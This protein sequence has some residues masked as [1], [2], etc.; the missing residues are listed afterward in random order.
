MTSTSPRTNSSNSNNCGLRGEKFDEICADFADKLYK[1]DLA[2]APEELKAKIRDEAEE[3]TQQWDEDV[4]SSRD[5]KQW[6][7]AHAREPGLEQLLAEHHRLGELILDIQDEATERDIRNF[8]H[9]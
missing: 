1:V 7:K 6:D 5:P 4:V 2:T 8:P 9:P 3:S